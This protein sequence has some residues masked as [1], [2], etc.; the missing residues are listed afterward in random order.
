MRK[1]EKEEGSVRNAKSE[2]AINL[3]EFFLITC[4]EMHKYNC[5]ACLRPVAQHGLPSV[6][7]HH[8]T[9]SNVILII[10]NT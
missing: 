3:R 1:R 9:L 5:S 8:K 4:L 6:G 2:R 7:R 10:V